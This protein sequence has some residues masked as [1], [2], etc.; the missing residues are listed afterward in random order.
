MG[1]ISI[2]TGRVQ[3]NTTI[4]SLPSLYAGPSP[5]NPK[6][7]IWWYAQAKTPAP[8]SSVGTGAWNFVQIWNPS[9][10]RTPNTGAE[11]PSSINGLGGVDNMYP[12]E[13][14][15]YSAAS[16]GSY[17]ADNSV[18][19]NGDSPGNKADDLYTNYRI[20]DT[21]N[22]YIMYLPPPSPTVNDV[23]WVPI[24]EIDWNWSANVTRPGTSWAS[25]PDATD[26][27]IVATTSSGPVT[28]HPT[29]SRLRLPP[30]SG[31]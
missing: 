23:Q 16:P 7:G 5:A 6:G 9:R 8:F 4:S 20:A 28:L 18:H 19:D 21:F 27:G 17:P 29:W 1:S 12:Y 24:Y 2:A 25:W 26:A 15:P 11:Q 3:I 10:W 30:A 13:P 14:P 31:W 22:T